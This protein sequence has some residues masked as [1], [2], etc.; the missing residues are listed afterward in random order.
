MLHINKSLRIFRKSTED[1][2]DMQQYTKNLYPENYNMP[3]KSSASLPK[4]KDE[5]L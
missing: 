5:N 3:K 2:D 4:W 1:M